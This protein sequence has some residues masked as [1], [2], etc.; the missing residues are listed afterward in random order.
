MK[1]SHDLEI[2]HAR[3]SDLWS[4]LH[5]AEQ[6][7]V[8]HEHL[9]NLIHKQLSDCLQIVTDYQDELLCKLY[10]DSDL[11]NEIKAHKQQP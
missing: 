9:H 2:E 11:V 5:R 8:N 10:P 4:F 1:Q 7:A 6:L 3:V